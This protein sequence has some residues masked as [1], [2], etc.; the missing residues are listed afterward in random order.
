MQLN[1]LEKQAAG[2]LIAVVLHE[3]EHSPKAAALSFDQLHKQVSAQAKNL[4]QKVSS[5]R[6]SN[7]G[8]SRKAVAPENTENLVVVSG[9][10]YQTA[11]GRFPIPNRLVPRHTYRA[12]QA[13]NHS[14]KKEIGQSVVIQSGYR[15]PAYQLFVF[16]FQLRKNSWDTQKTLESVALPGYSEHADAENQAMDIKAADFLGPE[17]MY[18]FSRVPAYRWMLENAREFGFTLSYP[19][20]NGTGTRFE[21]WH[22]RHT[23]TV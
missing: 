1:Y 12:F 19:E 22:W 3:I 14:M 9:Q 16:L 6:P 23:S 8:I 13:M 15:S 11:D 20:K 2:E 10:T 4:S 7:Y 5:L 21:P 17:S 18:D